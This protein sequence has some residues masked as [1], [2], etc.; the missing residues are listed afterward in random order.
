MI[1]KLKWITQQVIAGA[2]VA[3]I[4]MMLLIGF[5]GYLNP[6]K[7][8]VLSSLGLLFPFFL[9]INLLFLVFWL[10][11]VPR[12]AYIP[13]L[14]FILAFSPIRKF[15]PLNVPREAPADA[16]KVMSYNVYLFAG[17]ATPKGEVND[18]LQYI[19][20]QNADIVCL[21][22]SATHEVG[23]KMV[24]SVINARYEYRDTVRRRKKSCDVL[25]VYSHFP[26]I[27]HERI[28]I[29]SAS[30]IVAAFHLKINDDTVT[31]INAHL[32]SVGLSMEDK[33]EFKDLV[34]GN[35]K[36]DSAETTSKKLIDKIGERSAIR[37]PQARAVAQYISEHPGRSFIVCGDFNDGP[38][39]YT[40]RIVSKG[41]TDCFVATGNGMGISYHNN[42][43]FVRIDNIM[44]SKDWVPY[45]CHIDSKIGASDHYPIICW[46]KKRPNPLK[47]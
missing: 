37:A 42:A 3:T 39:S 6:E 27:D 23:Q 14:G 40:H 28:P 31:V 38:L 17:W 36:A 18:I 24:D 11:F 47:N 25:S 22:E 32:E 16:I 33:S 7:F 20:D 21:Q 44:C 41:L 9:F 5:S 4:L 35:L 29:E 46:L 15:I 10:V 8:P 26:I 45:N 2:N 12:K 13:I 43:F 1:K 19:Y 30:N 34:K